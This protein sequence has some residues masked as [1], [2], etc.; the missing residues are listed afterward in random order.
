LWKK[1]NVQKA[2]MCWLY[3]TISE[4]VGYNLEGIMPKESITDL[5]IVRTV[6][7]IRKA[8]IE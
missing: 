1:V 8:L 5:R 6:E 3:D 7:A 4:S 2:A